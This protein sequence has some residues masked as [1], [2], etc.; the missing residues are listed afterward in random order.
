MGFSDWIPN[1]F[2]KKDEQQPISN[3]VPPTTLTVEPTVLTGGS[4]SVVYKGGSYK[5]KKGPKGGKFITVKGKKVYLVR[6]K[7]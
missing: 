1:P 5:V 4:A 6:K 2:A 7:K 3:A